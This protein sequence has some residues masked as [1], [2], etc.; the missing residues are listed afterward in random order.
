MTFWWLALAV[1]RLVRWFHVELEAISRH[2][3]YGGRKG[4]SRLD[5]TL[6]AAKEVAA[7]IFISTLTTVIVFLPIR[8]LSGIAKLLFVPLT[9]TIAVALFG[10][11]FVSRTVT[12]LMCLNY[13]P[14]EKELDRYRQ[15]FQTVPECIFT[16]ILESIESFYENASVD[17]AASEN[18]CYQHCSLLSIVARTFHV[19][20]NRI[21]PGSGWKQ[22][23]LYLLNYLSVLGMKKP[24]LWRDKWKKSFFVS[25]WNAGSNTDVGITTNVKA[26]SSIGGGGNSGTM[27]EIFSVDLC[28]QKIENRSVFEIAARC[29]T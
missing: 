18:G 11:F 16:N 23:L 24:I 25:A 26:A 13:L 29:A 12:P 5:A 9:I 4:Q 27:Q 3:N 21:F 17:H 8:L 19:H 7:P 28:R 1:G 15:N 20:R 10:S 6:D 22:I 14:P 2:Y